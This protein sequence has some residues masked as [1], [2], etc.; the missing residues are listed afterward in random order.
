MGEVM[1]HEEHAKC[2]G[3]I[4]TNL[5]TL[6]TV[7]RIFLAAVN[8][9]SWAMPKTGDLEVDEN[10]LTNFRAFGPL[11]DRYNATLTVEERTQYAVNTSHVRIRDAFAHGR[12]LSTGD[13]FPQHF[14]SSDPHGTAK[15]RSNSPRS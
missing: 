2:V 8:G 7:I 1:T 12:L 15:S 4:I 9:Q 6:E 3:A 13:V 11:I 10:Y 14:T 5:Q